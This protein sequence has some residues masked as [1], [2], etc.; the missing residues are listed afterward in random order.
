MYSQ[1]NIQSPWVM[2]AKFSSV[3]YIMHFDV[4]NVFILATQIFNVSHTKFIGF[5][6]QGCVVAI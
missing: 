1:I 2:D 5:L 4:L 6:G 3:D